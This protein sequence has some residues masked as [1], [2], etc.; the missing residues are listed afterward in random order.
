MCYE[1]G[2]NGAR[3]LNQELQALFHDGDD[4]IEKYGV[5]YYVGDKV[6]QIENNYDHEIYNGE[7][8]YIADIN[9][10]DQKISINFDAK[11]ISYGFNEL[12]QLSLSYAI[13]IHKSQGSEYNCVIIP[14]T[15]QSYMML[16]RNLIYTALT[17][18]KKLVIIIGEKKLLPLAVKEVRKE[19]RIT[20]LGD[21]L[22]E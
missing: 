8:G 6:M 13:T 5:K 1:S 10:D 17:R 3:N 18:G 2:E 12:D 21:L 20:R 14:I 4:Y 9:Y 22:G 19:Q 7:T 15:M 11:Q 16:R